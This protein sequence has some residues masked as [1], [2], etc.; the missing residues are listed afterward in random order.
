MDDDN[1][2]AIET[3]RKYRRYHGPA[4]KPGLWR[5][6]DD[7]TPD[8]RFKHGHYK[9]PLYSVWASMKQRC[10]DENHKSFPDYGGRGIRVCDRWLEFEPF[11]ADV[12][13]RPD[14]NFTLERVNTNG[15][16]EPANCVW[17]TQAEQQ[18]NRT[19]TKLSMVA[20]REIRVA[21]HDG[22]MSL[23]RLA[24]KFD[25]A[26]ATIYKIL[27]NQIYVDPKYCRTRFGRT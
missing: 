15:N 5:I 3:T 13:S 25:V 2:E 4:A 12:G 8:G 27:N 19:N 16:Y 20:A 14:Q 22:G 17:A 7:G 10:L 6:N 23:C 18:R 1:I 11:L 21:Y 24:R 26:E 9:H